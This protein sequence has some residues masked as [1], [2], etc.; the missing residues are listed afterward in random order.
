M[1]VQSI[2]RDE[3]P[4]LYWGFVGFEAACAGACVVIA[5]MC[6]VRLIEGGVPPR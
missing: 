2:S 5:V 4:L 3:Q 6:A 1:R